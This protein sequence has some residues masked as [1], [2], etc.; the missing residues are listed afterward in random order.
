MFLIFF[1]RGGFWLFDVHLKVRKKKNPA[2]SSRR[3]NF[4]PTSKLPTP[5]PP[6][7]LIFSALMLLSIVGAVFYGVAKSLGS[8]RSR[9]WF[10]GAVRRVS[11]RSWI[12]I[13]MFPKIVGF[14]PEIIHFNRVFHYKPSILGYST[15]IFGN[16]HIGISGKHISLIYPWPF[17]KKMFLMILTVDFFAFV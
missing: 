16:T 10:L 14:C 3:N 1:F 8:D 17:A 9:F 2:F 13:W 12:F 4:L 5:S 6:E 11:F 15:P 7:G